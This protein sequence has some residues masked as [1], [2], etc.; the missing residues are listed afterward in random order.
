MGYLA[1]SR[2]A[3]P[4]KSITAYDRERTYE[5]ANL[6]VSGHA[7]EAILMDM[8]GCEVHKWSCEA[9]R[10]WPELARKKD[11]RY[12]FWRRAHLM[13]NGDLYAIFDGVGLIKSW[14]RTQIRSGVLTTG[15]IMISALHA[16]GGYTC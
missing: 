14:T 15:R 6:V 3:L 11:K 16:T 5:G 13:D 1:G 8:D 10:V 7:P 12:T 9:S 2:P 4:R